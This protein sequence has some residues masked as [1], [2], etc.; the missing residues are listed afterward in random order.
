MIYRAPCV[1]FLMRGDTLRG[2][3]VGGWRWKSRVLWA[4]DRGPQGRHIGKGP[5]PPPQLRYRTSITQLIRNQQQSVRCIRVAP[6]HKEE[7]SL[8]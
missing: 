1:M 7:Y 4:P 2:E 3:V 5:P 6:V 8:E